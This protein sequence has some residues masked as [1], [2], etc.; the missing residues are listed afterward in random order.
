MLFLRFTVSAAPPPGTKVPEKQ[1]E[2]INV[3]G[4][5]AGDRSRIQANLGS[6]FTS[7]STLE[8]QDM[9]HGSRALKPGLT[10]ASSFVS[11]G[12]VEDPKEAKERAERAKLAP[13]LNSRVS[14]DWAPESLLCK[15][16]DV[17][18]PF[19][20]RSKPGPVKSFKSDSIVLTETVAAASAAAVT[21]PKP[22]T[23][24]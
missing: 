15:R 23:W 1:P 24:R 10:M 8:T 5:A 19:E 4:I 12:A 3:K 6:M 9:G 11:A 18:D 20:G 17:R 22:A 7:G 13:I 21:S 14:G 2:V 16:F